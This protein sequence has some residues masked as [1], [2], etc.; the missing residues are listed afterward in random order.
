MPMMNGD[1]EEHLTSTTEKLKAIPK[2]NTDIDLD[3]FTDQVRKLGCAFAERHDEISPVESILYDLRRKIGAIP[4]IP[5]IT[6][7]H[8]AVNWQ[9]V[10]R[11][12][13]SM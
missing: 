13:L 10:Q 1:D 9:P 11:A 6:V 12:L 7:V 2:V 4:S 5:F 8:S 3:D